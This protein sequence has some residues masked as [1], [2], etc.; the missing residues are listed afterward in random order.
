MEMGW[1]VLARCDPNWMGDRM[2]EWLHGRAACVSSDRS[3]VSTHPVHS[4]MAA[5]ACVSCVCRGEKLQQK[6][7]ESRSESE[8][9]IVSPP[10]T[11]DGHIR[12]TLSPPVGESSNWP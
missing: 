2:V 7:H 8:F 5:C 10:W 12:Q 3:W 9:K 6:K 4:E 11:A 1:V